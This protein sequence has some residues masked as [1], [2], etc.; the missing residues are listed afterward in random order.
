[1][2]AGAP[3]G[4]VVPLDPAALLAG[5]RGRRLCLAL[6]QA[7]VPEEDG[8]GTLREA[9]MW[10]AYHLD[11]GRG[12]SVRVLTTDGRDPRDDEL[13]HPSV[14]EVAALL[15]GVPAGTP[16][17][18][19]LHEALGAAVDTARYW[20][21]PDGEDVLAAT[22]EVVAALRPTAAAVAA[23]PATAWWTAP[24]E[25]GTQR[26]VA[27]EDP[28]DV[29]AVRVRRPAAQVLAR[30]AADTIADEERALA[31]RPADPRAPWSGHWWS[32][33]PHDLLRT[34]RELGDRGAAGLWFVEDSYGAER[35]EVTPVAVDPGARV[36]ELDG[37]A[38]WAD[39]CRRR[40][41]EVTASRRHDWFRATGR[42]DVRWVL[43]D[44]RAVA[45][46]ADAVHLTVAG[47]L[48]T[49]GRAVEVD[50]GVASV[51]AG[52]DPDATYWLT[53]SARPVGPARAWTDDDGG[54]RPA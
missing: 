39:L 23:A 41:L 15:A 54:W 45:A 30:W 22:P 38:A 42:A 46:E 40:P 52:W 31:E 16:S 47:Y 14:A 49:A 11:P 2:D 29:A 34:T 25:P 17:P 24:L 7:A 19:T 4:P 20:Q 33:P 21:E 5:P 10:A 36:L 18:S 28:V 9:V 13:P 26:T 51:L 44:W 12:R 32:A 35:A 48:T 1:M 6:A 3:L 27:F 43:P 37:P 50:D 8:A 53:A